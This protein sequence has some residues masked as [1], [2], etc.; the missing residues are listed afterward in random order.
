MALTKRKTPDELVERIELTREEL[1]SEARTRLGVTGEGDKPPLLREILEKHGLS[2]YPLFALGLLSI[3]D[4]FQGYAFAVLAPEVSATLGIS[5][6]AIAGIIAI[7]TLASAVGPLPIAAAAQQKARRALII[8]A[9]GILWSLI[10]IS[11]GFVT[12]IAGLMVVLILDGLTT[13]SVRALHAPFLLDSYPA[14]S[15]VRVLSYYQASNSFGNVLAPLLVAAFVGMMGLTW[16]GV[17]VALGLIS[18]LAALSAIRLRDPGFGRWDSEQI[19]ATVRQKETG[20]AALAQD[21]LSESDVALGFFEIVRRLLLIPTIQRIL[22]VQ[23][24][25]GLLLIPLQTFLAFFLDEI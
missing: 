19:R 3:V 17:F 9:T 1:R 15:R 11:T 21:G 5:K 16:R 2:A 14:E 12:A 22:V 6:A 23:I 7:N 10:A 25:F 13:A 4:S 8:V 18:L 24:V 20:V